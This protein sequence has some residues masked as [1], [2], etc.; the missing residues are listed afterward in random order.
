MPFIDSTE[1]TEKS[2]LP[3]W[4][5][6][7]FHSEHMTFSYYEIDAGSALHEHFHPNEEVWNVIEGELEVTVGSDVVVVG[8]GGAAVVPSDISHS[9]RAVTDCRAIVVDEGVRTRVGGVNLFDE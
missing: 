5:G 6:R 3:G 7:F 2:P 4:K 9:A 1:L 8:A